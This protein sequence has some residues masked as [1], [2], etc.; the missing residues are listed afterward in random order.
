MTYN[1]SEILYL[2]ICITLSSLAY[3]LHF[4]IL[5][6]PFIHLSLFTYHAYFTCVTCHILSINLGSERFD[7]T[8]IDII[9]DNWWYFYYNLQL[10]NLFCY[11]KIQNMRYKKQNGNQNTQKFFWKRVYCPHK[12]LDTYS[13]S[14]ET[15]HWYL[16]NSKRNI[17]SNL[18]T[19]ITQKFWIELNYFLSNL[20]PDSIRFMHEILVLAGL[21]SRYYKKVI[22]MVLK[23]YLI[24]LESIP[25]KI[26]PKKFKV[27]LDQRSAPNVDSKIN[28]LKG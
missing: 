19:S 25:W 22:A 15:N 4:S 28:S 13:I 11:W 2:L 14:L 8:S 18:I 3:G 10:P 26:A 5:D 21:F 16:Q 6:Y 20:Q 12:L 17:T 1:Q 24:V 9:F 23:Y 7:M 27:V